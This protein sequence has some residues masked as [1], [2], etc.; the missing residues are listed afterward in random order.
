[1]KFIAARRILFPLSA[2]ALLIATIAAPV[3]P[4]RAWTPNP[5]IAIASD[6]NGYGHVT[7]QIPDGQGGGKV[8]IVYVQPLWLLMQQ[9]LHKA[10]M[11][12]LKVIDHSLVASGITFDGRTSYLKSL[13]YGNLTND[14]CQYVVVMPFIPDVASGTA[15]PEE[16]VGQLHKLLL[17]LIEKNNVGT[18]FV[19]DYYPANPSA[20]TADNIG[21]KLTPDRIIAFDAKIKDSCRPDGSLGFY[22][23]V[24]CLHTQDF[25]D[26]MDTSYVLGPTNHDQYT[27]L[28]YRATGFTPDVEAYFSATP[29]GQLLGDGIHLSLAGRLRLIDGLINQIKPGSVAIPTVAATDAPTL[30]GSTQT[31]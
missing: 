9:E 24:I 28:F 7:F 2:V 1:M 6:S 27:A 19:L 14:L 16:Y 4:A 5:C 10:G 13:S 18:I 23:Q 31:K 17:G 21:R 15:T 26:Q 11:D 29:N 30:D 3:Q 20:F 22:K 8:G 25:F 12:D